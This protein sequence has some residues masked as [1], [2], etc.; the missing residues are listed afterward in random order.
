MGRISR[1]LIANR[2]EIAVRIA[3]TAHR[4]G[5]DTVGVYSEPDANALHV[6]VVDRARA[7]GGATP[8]E[9]YLRGDAILAAAVETGAD[10]I[11][12]GYGF[13]AEN[14]AFAR[15]VVDAGLIW[16]GPTPEQIS[17]LGDKVAAKRAAAEAGVPT[18]PIFEVASDSRGSEP[19]L[20]AG[21]PMPAL[22]T[23]AAGGGGRGMR[24]VRSED[25]LAEAVAA[26]AREAEAAF[27]SRAVFIEP[28]VERG[29]H[30]EVQIL[31]D[32]EG[33]VIHFGERECSIQRRNQKVIEEAPSAGISAAIRTAL[34]DGAVALARAVGYRNA[35]TVEFLVGDDG[36]ITFLEVNTRLQVEHP[37]TEAVT[38]VDLVELQL[39]VAAGEPLG[40][41]Q[42]DV[43]IDGHAIEVRLVAED[44]A[45]NWLP[46]TGSLT[47]F[48]IGPGVRVDAGF[49]TGGEVSSRYDSLLAKVVAWGPTR[50][51]AAARLGRALR[52][53]EVS[54]VATNL[55]ALIAI[56]GD[57]D[58]LAA[59]TPTAYLDEHADLLAAGRPEGVDRTALLVAAVMAEEHRHHRSSPTSFA[60]SGW[61]NLRTRG[62][63]MV[64]ALG[65][66]DHP[67][68]YTRSGDRAVVLL[69]P[70]PEV[71]ED[72]SLADD[73]RPRLDV[74]LL[75]RSEDLQV[76]EV[77]G[78]RTVVATRRHGDEIRT[79]SPQGALV[80]RRR[81][82]FVERHGDPAAGGGP[83]SPLPGTVISIAVAEGDRV[84]EGD[85]LLVIEAMKMEH[86]I[87]AGFE[88][89]AGAVHFAVGDR[90]DA[91]DLLVT[92][93]PVEAAE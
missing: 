21:V 28:Y 53:S 84:A 75:R 51:D 22:V 5:I 25:E 64:L 74:R 12:P 77:D 37:V 54:G 70:W 72:G 71:L 65:D 4:L 45:A 92:L 15:R 10:A 14:A 34:C 91:G 68:E 69:G 55:H 43:R 82:R 76:I 36:T 3:R 8:A 49:A 33:N 90:V 61:R 52:T 62:Q 58:F 56:L 39:R 83:V 86:R 50:D 2:G 23:A 7:L 13:L 73:T 60:P 16:V 63:R 57:E 27:G 47:A 79:S 9:S 93:E 85:L 18:T 42:E 20:P 41:A 11:H 59:R 81:P 87:T 32:A 40:L 46:A 29:R 44:P 38:G 66:E 80:W 19:V 24:V 88:A 35:G 1:L 6:D 26:A 31:G 89:T 30:V 48:E 67:V 17:L 78:L